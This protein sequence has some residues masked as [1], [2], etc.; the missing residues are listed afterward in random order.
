M[1]AGFDRSQQESIILHALFVFTSL[2][3]FWNWDILESGQT[4]A[5]MMEF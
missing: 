4:N 2:P 3:V 1:N 5:V